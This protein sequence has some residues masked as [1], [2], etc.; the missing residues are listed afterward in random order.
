MLSLAAG[1]GLFVGVGVVDVVVEDVKLMF[2]TDLLAGLAYVGQNGSHSALM[3]A[4][5]RLRLG[6]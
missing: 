1:V 6:S 4:L 3:S 5:C 2:E